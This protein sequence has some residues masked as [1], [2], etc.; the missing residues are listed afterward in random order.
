MA[1]VT[2]HKHDEDSKMKRTQLHIAKTLYTK[3]QPDRP[4]SLGPRPLTDT[5]TDTHTDT[6]TDRHLPIHMQGPLAKTS[7]LGGFPRMQK[8]GAARFRDCIITSFYLLKFGWNQVRCKE[9]VASFWSHLVPSEFEQME[10]SYDAI[11][12]PCRTHFLHR[13]SP[14]K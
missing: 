2:S 9:E 7:H 1:A 4:S 10:G 8:V 12:E 6:Q 5:H 13:G 11:S 14:H 3:F